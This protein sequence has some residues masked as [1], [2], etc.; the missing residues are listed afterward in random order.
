MR[1]CTLNDSKLPP[2]MPSGNYQISLVFLTKTSKIDE[3]FGTLD[4]DF[5]VRG[6]SYI[7]LGK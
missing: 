2:V 3:R 6:K 5:I 1:D 4:F 7:G